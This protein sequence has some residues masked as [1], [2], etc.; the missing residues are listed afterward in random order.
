M[1]RKKSKFWCAMAF[2]WAVY[3]LV[4]IIRFLDF[5]FEVKKK[6]GTLLKQFSRKGDKPTPRNVGSTAL[7]VLLCNLCS[8]MYFAARKSEKAETVALQGEN[9]G[10]LPACE[11][12]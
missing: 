9:G 2:F 11:N 7:S 8:K 5:G 6:D 3:A 4:S 12:A 1:K 10:E